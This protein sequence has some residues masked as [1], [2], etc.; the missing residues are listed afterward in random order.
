MWQSPFM[1]AVLHA[2]KRIFPNLPEDLEKPFIRA[3]TYG[4]YFS[5]YYHASLGLIEQGMFDKLCTGSTLLSVGSGPAYLECLL[6]D[7][8]ELGGDVKRVP[9]RSITLSDVDHSKEAL[10]HLN[11]PRIH[12]NALKTWPESKYDYIIFPRSLIHITNYVPNST[13]VQ[14]EDII[15]TAT[16]VLLQALHHLKQYGQIRFDGFCDPSSLEDPNA[17]NDH[18]LW[19]DIIKKLNLMYGKSLFPRQPLGCTYINQ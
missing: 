16:Q 19:Q 1:K 11:I 9:A 2:Q 17:R 4:L 14:R 13:G 7:G 18:Q 3:P 12:L 6:V 15:H 8:L 5:P 10:P